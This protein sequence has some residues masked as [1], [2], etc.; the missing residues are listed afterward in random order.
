MPVEPARTDA[1]TRHDA[2]L[3]VSTVIFAL[4]RD[5]ASGLPSLWIPL[6]RRTRDPYLDD[7]ALPGGWLPDDEELSDAAARTLGETTGLSPKYLE[8]LYT[9][10]ALGRSPGGRVVSVVYW[11]LVQSDEAERATTDENVRWCAADSLGRL[12]FDHN[13][14]VEYALWRLRTKMEYARIA[15]A[16]LGDTFTLA[17]LRE[18][19][20]AVLQRR[21]DPANFRR[22]MEASGTLVDTGERLS[23]TPHRPPKLY[24]Y[25][26]SIDLA[27]AGPLARTRA[28]GNGAH[29]DRVETDPILPH[30][31]MRA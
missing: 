5:E 14:I 20:E 11:A 23:G 21:L 27:D 3:A 2:R 8:Q 15:H 16:F 25:D 30:P 29:R 24:R 26:A 13:R 31:R 4:R 19:H 9:F 12:A 7:W 10:G 18:V 6:V 28:L 22:T 17:Q 1:T